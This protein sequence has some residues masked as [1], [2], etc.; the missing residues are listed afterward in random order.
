MELNSDVPTVS[1]DLMLGS[2]S[3]ARQGNDTIHV[4]RG[5]IPDRKSLEDY[6]IKGPEENVQRSF[7]AGGCVNNIEKSGR[8]W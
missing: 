5:G 1:W 8:V 7:R 2:Q 6:V 3:L 4:T